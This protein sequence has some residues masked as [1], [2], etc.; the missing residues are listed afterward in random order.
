MKKFKI[1]D[2]VKV[3]EPRTEHHG[4]KGTVIETDRIA[5]QL[6]RRWDYEVEFE[7]YETYLYAPHELI[8]ANIVGEQFLFA[9]MEG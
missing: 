1:G 2:K 5:R 9:F 3:N 7:S 6:S 8:N 4:K